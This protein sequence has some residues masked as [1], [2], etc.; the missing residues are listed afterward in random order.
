MS[1]ATHSY[2]E[3]EEREDLR[4]EVRHPAGGAALAEH[5]HGDEQQADGEVEA[6]V[7]VV[8]RLG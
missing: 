8:A 7:D 5:L 4:Q 6:L 3:E 1:G 2:L